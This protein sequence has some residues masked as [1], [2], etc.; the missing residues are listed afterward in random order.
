MTLR[1]IETLERL[2]E[3]LVRAGSPRSRP[4]WPSE[5]LKR[6]YAQRKSARFRKKRADNAYAT[7]SNGQCRGPVFRGVLKIMSFNHRRVRVYSYRLYRRNHYAGMEQVFQTR[8]FAFSAK[9]NQLRK[10]FRAKHKM[11]ALLMQRL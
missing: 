2:S 1:D 4:V 11:S 7:L 8:I 6:K 10:I 9:F 5:K 3:D